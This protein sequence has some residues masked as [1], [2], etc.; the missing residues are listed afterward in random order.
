MPW[1]SCISAPATQTSPSIPICQLYAYITSVG[2]TKQ[3]QSENMLVPS[4]P[5]LMQPPW[6]VSINSSLLPELLHTASGFQQLPKLRQA[7]SLQ[8]CSGFLQRLFQ[9]VQAFALGGGQ[10]GVQRGGCIRLRIR[11]VRGLAS[12]TP[13]LHRRGPVLQAPV[14]QLLVVTLILV[15]PLCAHLQGE[16]L[17]QARRAHMLRAVCGLGGVA[18]TGGCIEGNHVRLAGV[19]ADLSKH[20]IR[21]HALPGT[22]TSS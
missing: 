10:A 11:C 12:S 13:G 15:R 3:T 7:P 16:G 6:H 4:F 5:V 18:L 17:H 22:A 9:A 20:G 8:Q 2:W 19:P 14:R 1:P 21:E